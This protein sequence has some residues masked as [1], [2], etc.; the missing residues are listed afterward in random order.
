MTMRTNIPL[1]SLVG[2]GA[3]ACAIAAGGLD[4]ASLAVVATIVAL[5]GMLASLALSD[6]WA[7]DET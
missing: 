4:F 5:L 2:T 6:S 3:G 7:S 1:V